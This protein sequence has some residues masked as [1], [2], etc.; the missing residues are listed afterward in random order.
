MS[1]C[2]GTHDVPH[3]YMTH[4]HQPLRGRGQWVTWLAPAID[5]ISD[6]EEWGQK[7]TCSI[8]FFESSQSGAQTRQQWHQ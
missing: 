2:G 8:S 4:T 5:A 6:S 3:V 1:I 7:A